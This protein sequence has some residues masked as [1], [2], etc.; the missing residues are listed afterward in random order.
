MIGYQYV[1]HLAPSFNLK[2][3]F[4]DVFLCLGIFPTYMYVHHMHVPLT[5]LVPTEIRRGSDSLKDLFLN[6]FLV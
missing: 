5:C 2:N 1:P 3:N 4:K 6:N